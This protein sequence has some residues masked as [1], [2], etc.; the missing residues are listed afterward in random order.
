MRG[1]C[2]VE[3]GYLNQAH[4]F[5]RVSLYKRGS[6]ITEGDIMEVRVYIE[7]Q[8]VGI[9]LSSTLFTYP[10]QGQ[11]GKSP[12]YILGIMPWH[13]GGENKPNNLHH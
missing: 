8:N 4:P 9:F 1:K 7:K 3:E 2:D 6:D 10:Y 13:L 12:S 11:G 5:P